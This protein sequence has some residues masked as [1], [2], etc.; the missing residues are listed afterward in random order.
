MSNPKYAVPDITPALT[1]EYLL[2]RRPTGVPGTIIP[3]LAHECGADHALQIET[4]FAHG[5]MQAGERA[6]ED[7]SERLCVLH[8]P[9][10]MIRMDVGFIGRDDTITWETLS[11]IWTGIAEAVASPP[12]ERIWET[13]VLVTGEDGEP[14]TVFSQFGFDPSEQASAPEN[15]TAVD[16]SAVSVT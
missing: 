13:Y 5:H 4:K 3:Q 9:Y 12:Y 8:A 11:D 7:C 16:Y 2:D 1:F 10:G 14:V 15:S 6:P